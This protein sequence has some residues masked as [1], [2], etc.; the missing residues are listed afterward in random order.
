ME[1]KK[2]EIHPQKQRPFGM[3][4]MLELSDNNFKGTVINMLKE[5]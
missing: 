1:N 3:V 5:V 4:Q 2:I